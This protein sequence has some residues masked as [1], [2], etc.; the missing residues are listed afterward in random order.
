[1]PVG[2]HD[3]PSPMDPCPRFSPQLTL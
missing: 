2:K 1:L 3:A